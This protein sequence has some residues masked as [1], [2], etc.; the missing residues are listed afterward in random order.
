MPFAV[1]QPG[2]L[3]APDAL[4]SVLV[5]KQGQKGIEGQ[6]QR[7]EEDTGQ[8]AEGQGQKAGGVVETIKPGAIL[9]RHCATCHHRCSLHC[10]RSLP[11]LPRC[12]PRTGCS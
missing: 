12:L 8:K 11:L 9:I 6:G 3:E 7:A 4:D 2:G 1:A 10:R 5:K